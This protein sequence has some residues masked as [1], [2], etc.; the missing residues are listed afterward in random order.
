M[1]A[2]DRA[3]IACPGLLAL[4]VNSPAQPVLPPALEGP[5][6]APLMQRPTTVSAASS[7]TL[8]PGPFGNSVQVN[9][10]ALGQNIPGD[11]A[12][13]P[14]LC[15]DPTNP[16]RIAVGWRQFDNVLSNFRQAGWGYST[17]GGQSWR[18]PGVLETNV[19]RSDPV[20][21]SDANGVFHYLSLNVSPIFVCDVWTSASGGANWQ[22]RA[23]AVGGDKAWFII[24]TT[25]SSGRGHLYQV[26]S[27]AGNVTTNRIFSRSTDGGFTWMNPMSV[28][29]TPYWNTLDVGPDGTLFIAGWNGSAF[30]LNRSTN[31]R[32]ASVT[33]AFDLTRQ[34]NLGGAHVLNPAIN[35]E[36]LGGQ[37][38]VS[39]DKSTGTNRGNVYVLSTVTGASAHRSDVTFARSTNG[40]DT[41]SAP[42]RLNDDDP[43]RRSW[44]WFGTLSTAPDG[45]IDACWYDTRSDTNALLTQLYYSFS[46]DGGRTW[47]RNYAVSPA[48]NPTLGYPN[49]RKIGDYIGMVSLTNSVNIAYAATFNGEQDIY[50]L[51]LP[52][53]DTDHDGLADIFDNCPSVFNPG[54][55]DCNGDG[56][57][58]ACGATPRLLIRRVANLVTVCWPVAAGCWTLQ[59][60]DQVRST[61]WTTFPLAPVLT[62]TNQC[63]TLNTPGTSRF[64]RLVRQ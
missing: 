11:A 49:Q 34:V 53:H 52:L 41:W 47:S 9:V 16:D 13:E 5:A 44:H 10:N 31:A 22:R 1:N 62:G 27:T 20:L 14:S 48:F 24:D 2:F 26:W 21:A 29:Q 55:E 23:S 37:P 19:L 43:A 35:P 42:L 64:F 54:Q 45:R 39:V 51:R 38:W 33:P 4:V 18:F 50:F 57:G 63:V 3:L 59:W 60:T 6:D 58:D 25:T 17:N 46:Q 32:N 12:N 15:L 8:I 28:P 56:I 61:N 36:G 7:P 30:W 40:G